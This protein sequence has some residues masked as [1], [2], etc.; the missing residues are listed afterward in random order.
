VSPAHTDLALAEH[1]NRFAAHHDGWEDVARAYAGISELLFVALVVAVI[2]VGMA[3]RRRETV[4]TGVLALAAAGSAVVAAAVV[5]R[6]V[7]RPRP[8][9][10]HPRGVHLFAHHA[11]DPGFPSDHAT[12]A[13]AIA[14]ALLLYSR[15]WGALALVAATILAL[16]RVAMGIHYPTDVLAGAAVGAL[17]ALTLHQPRVRALL[18]ALADRAGAVVDFRPRRTAA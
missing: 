12:A 10:A 16:T 2:L 17:A 13:F 8:F 6:A 1:A 4:V 7:D 14:V 18:H 15:R 9:V 11:A 5:A 3:T